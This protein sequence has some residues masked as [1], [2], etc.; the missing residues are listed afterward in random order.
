MGEISALRPATRVLLAGFS[1]WIVLIFL[2]TVAAVVSVEMSTM[3]LPDWLG[4]PSSASRGA[5]ARP[6]ASFDNILQ[7]PLFS[8]SRQGAAPVSAPVL[9]AAPAPAVLDQ[10]ITLKG[11]FISGSLAKALLVSSQNPLGIWVQADEELSGWKVVLIQPDEVV[12][13][14]QGQKRTVQLHP[15]GAK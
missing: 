2:V 4:V 10:G 9:A 5:S 15:G 1:G 14:A 12:L 6:P 3:S 8:R 13:Q 7:R 11:V